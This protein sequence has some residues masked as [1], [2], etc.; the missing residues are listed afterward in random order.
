MWRSLHPNGFTY[1]DFESPVARLQGYRSEKIPLPRFFSRN[2]DGLIFSNQFRRDQARFHGFQWGW[3]E[4]GI[5][6]NI[7]AVGRG[8]DFH[9]GWGTRKRGESPASKGGVTG[10]VFEYL[11][12]SNRHAQQH[13][14]PL[15][16]QTSSVP[17][18]F[19]ASRPSTDPLS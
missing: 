18:P 14:Q 4:L 12:H 2:P 16:S 17:T 5:L 15:F 7:L 10:L 19:H 8:A 3:D 9:D 6:P 11:S 1:W 13:V